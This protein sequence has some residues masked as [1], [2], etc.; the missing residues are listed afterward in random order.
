ME[1]KV[2]R[3]KSQIPYSHFINIWRGLHRNN[4]NYSHYYNTQNDVVKITNTQILGEAIHVHNEN[5]PQL[6]LVSCEIDYLIISSS[7][8]KGVILQDT[9]I[10][11]KILVKQNSR[12][13][14]I[15]ISNNSNIHGIQIDSSE[16]CFLSTSNATVNQINNVNK[17]K[18]EHLTLD[19]SQIKY[20][21]SG[22]KSIFVKIHI[23]LSTISHLSLINSYIDSLQIWQKSKIDT[24]NLSDRMTIN[25]VL[26]DRQI[27]IVNFTIYSSSI[28]DLKLSNSSFESI[29]FSGVKLFN[30]KLENLIKLNSLICSDSSYIEH[31]SISTQKLSS[32]IFRQATFYILDIIDCQLS[33]DSFLSISNSQLNKLKI[34]N[35]L[36]GGTFMLNAVSSIT[37]LNRFIEYPQGPFATEFKE[38]EFRKESEE[39]LLRIAESD[40]GKAQFIGCNFS[41][42]NK[43]EYKNSKMLEVFVADT[44]FPSRQNIHHPDKNATPVQVLEQ[45]RLALSQFKKIYENRGDNIRATQALAEEV[46]TYRAQ[47]K[48]EK[49]STQKERWNNRTERFNLWLNRI[50][51]YHGNNWFRAA[52]VTV[53]INWLFFYLYSLS[54][55][56]T[57]GDDWNMFGK[58][59]ASSFDFLNPVHKTDFLVDRFDFTLKI[60]GM[61]IFVDNLSRIV[62]A[63]FVYQTIAAFRKF[64]K[65]SG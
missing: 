10:H 38:F 1:E 61:A 58:L 40:L 7:N 18:I 23:T 15:A 64:G 31:L 28:Y 17:S 48:L 25:T 35:S 6:T 57:L 27:D 63:Y 26:I 53:L 46:E 3:Y 39:S 5:L 52:T 14:E 2:N 24:L 36:F 51:N 55:G 4:P 9:I 62:I 8:V 45:Q 12:V 65:K 20:L 60:G 34:S 50:S 29:H 13:N 21:T 59:L 47:L 11:Q 30:V 56:F 19:N 32:A 37:E 33:K 49:P 43:F 54:L 42:F 41:K 22:Q 16:L 44:E